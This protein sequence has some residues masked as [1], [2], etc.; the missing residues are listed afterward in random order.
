[1]ITCVVTAISTI[2]DDTLDDALRPS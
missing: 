2:N 1:V